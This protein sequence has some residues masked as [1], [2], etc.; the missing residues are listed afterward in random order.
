MSVVKSE[1]EWT[2]VLRAG[3]VT[4]QTIAAYKWPAVFAGTFKKDTFSKGEAELPDFLSDDH[5]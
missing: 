4:E 2:R 5:P 3:G 1:A